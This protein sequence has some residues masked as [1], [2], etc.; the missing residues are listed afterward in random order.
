M[1]LCGIGRATGA[2]CDPR[3]ERIGPPRLSM[4]AGAGAVEPLTCAMIGRVPDIFGTVIVARDTGFKPVRVA[5][6]GSGSNEGAGPLFGAV[7]HGLKTRATV[8]PILS[9]RRSMVTRL[10][11]YPCL[12]APLLAAPLPRLATAHPR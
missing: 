6:S 8:Q 11:G 5:S 3:D 1:H 9:A 4:D 2:V 7:T 12:P 10:K